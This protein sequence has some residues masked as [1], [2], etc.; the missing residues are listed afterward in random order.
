MDDSDLLCLFL[1]NQDIFTDEFIVDELLDFFTAAMVTTQN[2][3]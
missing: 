1:Q 2:A 3:T